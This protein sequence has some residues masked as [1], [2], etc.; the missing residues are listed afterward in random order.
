MLSLFCVFVPILATAQVSDAK[1]VDLR[2]GYARVETSSYVIDVP[3]GWK[4]SEETPWGQRKA[5]PG[6]GAGELGVMTAP[7]SQQGWGPTLD[8]ALYFINREE[9]GK[10]TPY[11]LVKTP[12]GYDAATFEVLDKEGFAARRFVMVKH[13]E[14][15]LLALSVRVPNR[16]EDEK[17]TAHFERMVKSARFK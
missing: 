11:K 13:P 5:K 1:V 17:W 6:S 2:D 15:G 8:T 14:K 4:V 12:A 7:P 10:A 16:K 3:K 9:S